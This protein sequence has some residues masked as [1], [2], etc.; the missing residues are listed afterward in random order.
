MKLFEIL[1]VVETDIVIEL[2][3]DALIAAV[4]DLLWVC[5]TVGV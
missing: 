5:V 4:A 2:A 1:A 3:E